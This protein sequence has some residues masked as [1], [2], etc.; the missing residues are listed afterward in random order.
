MKRG[1]ILMTV[2]AIIAVLF[3]SC[4]NGMSK[5]DSD[6]TS[7]T[8]VVSVSLGVEVE[9]EAAQ[10]SISSDDALGTLTFW[11]KATAQW[12]QDYPIHG[13]TGANFVQ[14]PSYSA[15][16]AANLGSFTAGPWRFD[17][18][19]RK[20]SDV[21][22]SGYTV[23][24]ID[25][26]KTT[27]TVI[28]TPDDGSDGTVTITVQIPTTDE[29]GDNTETM[30][31][32]YSGPDS[33]TDVEMTRG[34]VTSGLRTFTATVRDLTPGAYTFM[35][36]YTDSNGSVLNTGAAQAINVYAGQTSSITGIIDGK[37]WIPITITIKSPGFSAF[38]MDNGTSA[39]TIAPS[40]DLVYT[41]SATTIS[42]NAA[43]Y[44]WYV[45]GVDASTA[46]ATFTFSKATPKLYEVT[47]VASD[48]ANYASSI[49]RYVEV[50]YAASI[51]AGITNGTVTLT[52]GNGKV[53]A[54]GDIVPLTIAPAVGYK[55]DTLTVTGV[56][57][58]NIATDSY[59]G[60]GSFIMPAAAAEV[61]AT[62][63]TE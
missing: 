37:H 14:I 16:S 44:K 30:T 19:V 50:G 32:D 31:L 17:V 43:T 24:T 39:R 4:S 26:G 11:Y 20:G 6:G 34:A 38:T 42:G 3:A 61:S 15:G 59:S 63:V 46:T 28:V 29:D 22:Y 2:L 9:G 57:A 45:D 5:D 62:F 36:E 49:T 13:G 52:N 40:T 53:Y 7:S 18:E 27:P 12:A 41:A 10:K 8:K 55:L 58:G 56:A 47:C 48:G 51:A 25:T 35:F 23:Y 21:I 1:R 54:A 60:T 33:D